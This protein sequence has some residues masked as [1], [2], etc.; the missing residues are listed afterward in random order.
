MMYKCIDVLMNHNPNSYNQSQMGAQ[1]PMMP[2]MQG[3]P[4]PKGWRVRGTRMF[5]GEI[6]NNGVLYPKWL[7]RNSAIAYLASLIII[8]FMYNAYSMA[9]YYM[10]A[11]V[12]GILTFFLCGKTLYDNNSIERIRKEKRFERRVFWIA[13]IPRLLFTLILYWIFQ[14]NYGDAYG[15]ESGDAI[16]YDELGRFVAGMIGRGDFHFY[17]EISALSGNND[18]SDMGYGVYVGFIYWLTGSGTT[19]NIQLLGQIHATSALSIL[20]VRI[21]KCVLSSLTV[22]LIYRLAKRNFDTSVARMAAIFVALWPNFW[23]YCTCHLKEVE[24]VFLTVLFVE[25]AEQMLRS[26]Q[27]TAWKVIPVLLIAAAIF[28]FR[29]ALGLVALLALVFSVVMSSTRVVSWGKRIIVGFLAIALIGVVAGNRLQERA[30]SLYN[31]VQT[32]QQQENM[33]WRSR[34]THGN[35]FAKYA[36]KTVFAPL[37][38]SIPFPTMAKPFDGQELQQL[39]HGG[40]FIKNIMSC[41]TIFAMVLLLITGRWREHLLPLSFMLGYL[42]VLTMSTFAQS[43]RF[44]QPVMPLEFMFAAYG[45]SIAA[46]KKR[47][48]RWFMYWCVLMLIAAVAWNWFKLKGRGMI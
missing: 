40:N 10:L 19:E 46:T 11:G 1:G 31:Q 8:T 37:I 4:A 18:I 28:T 44:H 27:F 26:R 14:I 15:F 5:G 20:S 43:E 42:L 21:L 34:R 7:V 25:Q 13:F 12:I 32:N 24:M 3:S 17:D 45:L 33:E 30:Q 48:K 22:L 38:F 16:Y 41:F 29:T 35:E 36:G 39:N 2:P 47:Y 6:R 23:Y 9:W